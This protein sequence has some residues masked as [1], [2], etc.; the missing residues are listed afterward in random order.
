M[1]LEIMTSCTGARLY[2]PDSGR[3][4][5]AR[6]GFL[7]SGRSLPPYPKSAERMPPTC[8]L[9]RHVAGRVHSPRRL[10]SPHSA[11]PDIGRPICVSAWTP[12]NNHTRL[13]TYL[14]PR[15]GPPGLTIPHPSSS[16]REV[17]NDT[18]GRLMF[19]HFA[20]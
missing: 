11:I 7:S 1:S 16:G 5:L 4:T 15:P 9:P 12:P 8:L 13:K 20:D 19:D 6:A 18:W 3:S 14:R 17:I 10:Q 2:A